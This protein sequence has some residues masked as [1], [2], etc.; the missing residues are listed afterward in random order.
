MNLFYYIDINN[1]V[2]YRY[3]KISIFSLFVLFLKSVY[4]FGWFVVFIEMFKFCIR[5]RNTICLLK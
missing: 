4:R 3:M 1:I 2:Y 5:Y